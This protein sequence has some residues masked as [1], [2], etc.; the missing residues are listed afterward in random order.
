[1]IRVMLRGNMP[2]A[3]R[4]A[5]ERAGLVVSDP[6]DVIVVWFDGTE[7]RDDSVNASDLSDVSPRGEPVIALVPRT[8]PSLTVPSPAP[9]DRGFSLVEQLAAQFGQDWQTLRRHREL[10][11]L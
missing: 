8:D 5:L 11:G 4:R 9:R 6:G 10:D 2:G 3:I 1:M 7:R